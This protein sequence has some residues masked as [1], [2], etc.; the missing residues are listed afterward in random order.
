MDHR[1]FSRTFPSTRERSQVGDRRDSSLLD[2]DDAILSDER[3]RTVR[4]R[5]SS[6]RNQRSCFDA[7]LRA[8]LAHSVERRCTF[9]FVSR[10]Q[11]KNA[12]RSGRDTDLVALRCLPRR[13]SRPARKHTAA[14]SESPP[15]LSEYPA[16]GNPKNAGEIPNAG[17][18]HSR[19]SVRTD[20][21]GE[22]SLRRNA[23]VSQ[24][25]TV[26]TLQEAVSLH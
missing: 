14:R 8:D 18:H 21:G 26:F 12:R 3:D 13:R 11:G 7:R 15:P 9:L 10:K 25:R 1:P 22:V 5:E 20:R 16:S 19:L 4:S 2:D 6:P 24:T 23:R 17:E